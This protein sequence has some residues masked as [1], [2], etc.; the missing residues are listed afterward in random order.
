[1]RPAGQFAQVVLGNP[2]ANHA[3]TVLDMTDDYAL[4]YRCGDYGIADSYT[5]QV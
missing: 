5:V 2:F 1:M 4:T 3:F